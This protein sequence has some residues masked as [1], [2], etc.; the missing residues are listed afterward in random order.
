MSVLLDNSITTLA[1]SIFLSFFHA[2]ISTF[3]C[4]YAL[5]INILFPYHSS[6][7]F[8]WSFFLFSFLFNQYVSL[9]SNKIG[10]LPSRSLVSSHSHYIDAVKNFNSTLLCIYFI[11][12]SLT[13][14]SFKVI[15]KPHKYLFLSP[16][17]LVASLGF[18][19]LHPQVLFPKVFLFFLFLSAFN[20][21]LCV[22]NFLKF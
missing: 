3:P 20:L 1:F 8:S 15:N 18:V 19:Y 2:F 10:T 7:F 21:H 17:S 6:H 11:F 4:L 14:Y 13:F 9:P 12:F 16:K 5:C 22:K